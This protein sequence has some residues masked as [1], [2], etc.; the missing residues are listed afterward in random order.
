MKN[1]RRIKTM[2]SAALALAM[3]SGSI[4]VPQQTIS[5]YA[6]G[7]SEP[8]QN[9]PA[10]K[11][12]LP[13]ASLQKKSFVYTGEQVVPEISFEGQEETQKPELDVD[14]T[15]S[16]KKSGEDDPLDGAPTK[17]GSYVLVITPTGDTYTGQPQELS[18][19]IIK[20][21]PVVTAPEAKVDLVYDGSEQ[22]LLT[23]G[24]TDHGVMQY[25]LEGQDDWSTDVPKA[26]DA[27]TYYVYYKVQGDDNYNNVAPEGPIE[28]TIAPAN[29]EVTAPEAKVNLTYTGEEQELVTAGST[30]DGTIYYR[31]EGQDDWSTDVPKATDAD[32]YYVYYKVEGAVNHEG[33]APEEPIEVT[34]A[35]ADP[36][37]IAPQAEENLT[38][39]GEAQ[40]LVTAGSTEDGTIYYRL[41]GQDD[42]STD[43]PTAKDARGYTVYY[44]TVGNKNY[45]DN[46][47]GEVNVFIAQKE[48]TATLS[49]S[50]S[51]EYDGSYD[52]TQ[53]AFA[54]LKITL[55]G[56]CEGDEVSATPSN[57][58]YETTD[59][60]QNLKVI[61]K[62]IELSGASADNY[63][64]S[65]KNASEEIGTITPKSIE[66]AQISLK[67]AK[68]EYN[69]KEQ[70]VEIDKVT[71]GDS[72]LSGDDYDV[73]GNTE[74]A[75]GDYTLT[76]TGKGNY[77]GK[78]T[79]AW[80]ITNVQV[81]I[82][83]LTA[84][85]KEYDGKTEAELKGTAVVKKVSDN[86]VV[87][88]V[89]VS[90]VT[91]AFEDKTAGKNKTVI[92]TDASLSDANYKLILDQTKLTAN[93][94]PKEITFTGVKALDKA[95]DGGTR[96]EVKGTPVLGDAV[97]KDDITLV[98]EAPYAEFIDATAG[99]NKEVTLFGYSLK[100]DDADNYTLVL[101]GL[102]ATIYKG[103]YEPQLN[104]YGWTYGNPRVPDVDVPSEVGAPEY[105]YYTDEEC[106]K[107]TTSENGAEKE[108]GQPE[109]VGT[110]YLKAAFAE[111]ANYEAVKTVR[112]F[113]INK[114][115]Q[116]VPSLKDTYVISGEEGA[117]TVKIEGVDENY[118]YR[119]DGTTGDWKDFNS[120]FS[121]KKGAYY[122]R[123]KADRNHNASE[124]V[125]V[126][127]KKEAEHALTVIGGSGSGSY[128]K[129][130]TVKV[131][132]DVPAGQVFVGWDFNDIEISE[133]EPTSATITITIPD[134][135]AT[136]RAIFKDKKPERIS[137]NKTSVTLRPKDTLK[138]E[139]SY[140]PAD[141]KED[142]R[143]V[144]WDSNNEEVARV[145]E[146]G[147]VVALA[148]G[149]ATITAIL[150]QRSLHN[151]V[152]GNVNEDSE[153]TATCKITVVKAGGGSTGGGSSAG[154][155]SAGAG[156]TQDPAKDKDTSGQKNPTKEETTVVTEQDGSV[157]EV[158]KV[159]NADGS[160]TEKEKVTTKDGTVDEKVIV[161]AKDGSVTE[162]EKI[163]TKDGTVDEKVTVTTKDGTEKLTQTV[164]KADGSEVAIE[165]EVKANGD[166]HETT[167]SKDTKGKVTK[168]VSEEKTTNAKTGE[169]TNTKEVA[170]ANG[171]KESSSVTA[172]A[173]GHIEK[174][175]IRETTAKGK[176]ETVT[177]TATKSGK[178]TVDKIDAT[179]SNVVIPDQ[180]VD[181]NGVSHDVTTVK[182][183]ALDGAKKVKSIVVGKKVTKFEANALAGSAVNKLELNHVPKFAR[184]SL[185]NGK[186][187][188]IVVHSKADQKAVQKQLKVAGAPNAK[189][190]V[191]KSKK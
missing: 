79:A 9:N 66:G 106:K 16:Y 65:S 172:D 60:G 162:T 71:L 3:V 185:K 10:V 140:T 34:I 26:T 119:V 166:Y 13:T 132:A 80:S 39:T 61:A 7:D 17:V 31:L 6:E 147:T 91:A 164:H 77:T 186:K 11:E 85:N 170:L 143:G 29:R 167:V 178:L 49:G 48:L 24:S 130:A 157:K 144:W 72:E 190:K 8:G 22:P 92:L 83:G 139:V 123:K 30:E 74:T 133:N 84:V 191:V 177:L 115:N 169:V 51:K 145:D 136:L 161:T 45:Y 1:K 189:V 131:T 180:V 137:L 42:W 100:G 94:E 151:A 114:A 122:I 50:V 188:T 37:V 142:Y 81:Y 156:S 70:T 68:L 5:A 95:Y 33:F 182:A 46:P 134:H 159:N 76:I 110:Y 155:S 28:V 146:D 154:G 150:K 102:T 56:I 93:I 86:Q 63:T 35:K 62:G 38:Y 32:T 125:L 40:K 174:A 113:T 171:K 109:N 176:S 103:T 12:D 181:A 104:L 97:E 88:N 64:L 47:G 160:T 126:V 175:V 2:M 179:M 87:E 18:F 25:S 43:V 141:L 75:K 78:V 138:L 55:D 168:T 57:V 183:K 135:D 21:D 153:I 116:E 96:T 67:N 99:E 90:D 107:L 152:P 20:A 118:E 149:E 58:Y 69:G 73:S 111:T 14:Y 59:V 54:G 52:V 163:T 128:E 121:L 117:T 44:K 127:V 4:P 23:E 158:T 124:A 53:E 112:E 19:N 89:T 98:Q 27:D 15:V 105:T 148:E 41:K 82:D 187:M 101:P 36:A 108:G 165:K 129:G 120:D 184:N 173:S